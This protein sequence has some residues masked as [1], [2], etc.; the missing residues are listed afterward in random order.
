MNNDKNNVISQFQ[1]HDSS[2]NKLMLTKL[3]VKKLILTQTMLGEM[4]LLDTLKE[5]SLE[6]FRTMQR[7]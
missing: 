7:K 3:A 4:Y 5:K 1:L 2:K 6:F